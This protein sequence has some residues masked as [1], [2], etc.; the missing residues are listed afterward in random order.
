MIGIERMMSDTYVIKGYITLCGVIRVLVQGVSEPKSLAHT[1]LEC[2]SQD[3]V[4][5][6]NGDF[7]ARISNRH[8]E[9]INHNNK[10][11]TKIPFHKF[12]A[13]ES[14]KCVVLDNGYLFSESIKDM[15]PRYKKALD[16]AERGKMPDTLDNSKFVRVSPELSGQKLIALQQNSSSERTKAVLMP[17]G[18]LIDFKESTPLSF[19]RWGK[20]FTPPA[21]TGHLLDVGF[22]E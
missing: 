5:Y 18:T 7:S 11:I 9:I 21:W 14:R 13:V 10:V 1:G 16:Q 3:M 6:G 2:W 22:E 17:N 4:K 20:T 8:V 12:T 15:A 19:E